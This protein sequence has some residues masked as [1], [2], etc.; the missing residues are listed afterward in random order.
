[1]RLCEQLYRQFERIVQD[2]VRT[3]QFFVDYSDLNNRNGLKKVVYIQLAQFMLTTP[4]FI[5][6][7]PYILGHYNVRV[8]EEAWRLFGKML[9]EGVS[10]VDAINTI[11]FEIVVRRLKDHLEG[12]YSLFGKQ[13]KQKKFNRK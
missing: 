2:C 1:M 4:N 3:N 7:A 8:F 5:D 11:A 13:K 12:Y 9:H 6:C 10:P